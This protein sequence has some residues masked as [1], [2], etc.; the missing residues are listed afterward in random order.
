MDGLK[1]TIR[2][3]KVRITNFRSLAKVEI[4]L[5]P[6]TLL[7]GMNNSGKT[8]FL[9]AVALAF[10]G[11]RKIISRDDLFIDQHGLTPDPPIITI[12][13]KI[14]PTSAEFD[15][16]WALVFGN[17]IT[18]LL[19][20]EF[21]AF[22]TQINFEEKD[23]QA[24]ITQSVI[25]NWESEKADE[26]FDFNIKLRNLPFRFIQA[27]RD[28]LDETHS[29]MTYFG[30]LVSEIRYDETQR[31]DLESE[32][33]KLNTQAVEN[34]DIL[35]HLA[36][37]LEN[38]NTTVQT[39]GKGV[40]IT[41]FPK[42]VR[43]LH[44]NMMVHFQD[45]SSESFSLEYHGMGTRSWA[46]LLSFK[47]Y[48]K[49]Q[50]KQYSDE[51]IPFFPILALEEPEAH[52]HPNAQRQVYR[53]L[54]EMDGQKIIST[55]SPYIVSQAELNDIRYFYKTTDRVTIRQI[56]TTT[57]EDIAKLKREIAHSR[58]EILFARVIVLFEGMS[59]ELALSIFARHY[60][61]CSHFD[62]GIFFVNCGG[63]NYFSALT[64]AIQLGIPW[65]L[66]SDFDKDEVRDKV[67]KD[68]KRVADITLD[69][70]TPPSNI[71]LLGKAI[72]DYLISEGYQDQ[73]IAARN[74]EFRDSGRVSNP[75]TID[76]NIRKYH[77]NDSEL[78][79]DLKKGK[80]TLSPYYANEIVAIDDPAR[81][82]PPKIRQLFE[83][84]DSYLKQG[85]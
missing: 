38:L 2:M 80:T 52:L 65:C 51:N 40:E 54:A 11:E 13:I 49:W 79:A 76:A 18:P 17:N 63:N 50:K 85:L 70:F 23:D 47:A 83:V 72:E 66:F 19:G 82:I 81:K 73:L 16:D 53:Q 28:L 71:I 41:P 75:Q 37:E 10:Y 56:N 14:V 45:G 69:E 46:T 59:E 34:S 64:I 78:S 58:G 7:V 68:L 25:R 33:Q 15:S 12:D 1:D 39:Q 36:L 55:H 60:F 57:G 61:G 44:R 48:M 9:R 27:Q 35:K 26:S 43:D 24:M 8:S 30:K 4:T 20:R 3:E 84:I 62:K 32:L 6:I 42:K 67:I 5:A 77:P 31:N 74:N 21:F 29:P 22:R